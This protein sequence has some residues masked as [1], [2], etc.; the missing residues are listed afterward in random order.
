VSNS[1]S[2]S[3]GLAR[4]R[5]IPNTQKP[6]FLSRPSLMPT[7]QSGSLNSVFSVVAGSL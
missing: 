1:F 4:A 2:T 3:P 7:V 6:P 5:A